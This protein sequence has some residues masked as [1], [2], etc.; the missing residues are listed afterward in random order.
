MV[1]GEFARTLWVGSADGV[2]E[3]GPRAGRSLMVG[4]TAFQ[5]EQVP[6]FGAQCEFFTGQPRGLCGRGYLDRKL[7]IRAAAVARGG[8]GAQ[9]FDLPVKVRDLLRESSLR[10]ELSGPARDCRAVV[11][12]FTDVMGTEVQ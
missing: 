2:D 1:L 5:P 6:D 7:S 8:R 9:P 12:E 4:V 11:P 3:F 10:G